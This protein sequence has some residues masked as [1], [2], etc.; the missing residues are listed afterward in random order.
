MTVLLVVA[1]VVTAA[2]GDQNEDESGSATPDVASTATTASQGDEV[3]PA[4]VALERFLLKDGE[5]PGFERLGAARTE[6]GVEAFVLGG[7]VPDDDAQRL[8]RAG[9]V[10]FM[11]QPVGVEGGNAGVANVH[12]FETAQGARDWLK[13]ETREA[14][15]HRQIPDTRIDRFTVSGVP[16]A[17]GWT[18][19]DLHGNRIGTVSWVQGRC[20]LVIANEGEGD[21]VKP[22]STGATAIYERTGESARHEQAAS[23][24]PSRPTV[25]MAKATAPRGGPSRQRV[26]TSCTPLRVGTRAGAVNTPHS[27]QR[28]R[29]GAPWRFSQM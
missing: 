22:L 19:T 4:E 11:Y 10:A 21:F 7:D 3:Q 25:P 18:G 28:H 9:F 20:M 23:R 6:T 13:W 29:L 17:R 12:L 1:L 5:E 2:C 15:I 26:T 8:R 24:P 27:A 14:G 16:E